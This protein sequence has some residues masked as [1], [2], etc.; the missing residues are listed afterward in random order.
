MR[1][2]RFSLQGLVIVGAILLWTFGA[3]MVRFTGIVLIIDGVG[4]F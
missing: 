3:G 4:A 1:A 2:S